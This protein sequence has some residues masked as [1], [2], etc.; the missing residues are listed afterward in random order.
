MRV[1]IN[2]AVE[3]LARS[4][5]FFSALGFSFNE[6][7]CDDT[8][9]GMEINEHCA[10][11]LLTKAKFA[12][13]TPRPLADAGK[14]TEVLTALQLDSRAAVDAMVA[15]ALASGGSAVRA[16]EN[17][18]FMYGHAFA[19]PDG[20]IWEPFWMDLEAMEKTKENAA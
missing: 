9:L 12:P 13:F 3:D 10:A 15:T 6:T 4:R 20:H 14:T 8:A 2:L 16:P 17:H 19:D 11:M 18:G 7:F 5:A 1:Y